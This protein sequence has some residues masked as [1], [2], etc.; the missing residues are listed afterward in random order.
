MSKAKCLLCSGKAKYRGLCIKH[1]QSC[2][3]LVRLGDETWATLEAKD[4]AGP[5]GTRGPKRKVSI[6]KLAKGKK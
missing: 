3:R 6:P 4:L 2:A 5:E 1:Y